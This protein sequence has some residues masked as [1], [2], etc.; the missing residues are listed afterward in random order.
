VNGH[1]I[2]LSTWCHEFFNDVNSK[3][4]GRSLR[5]VISE[6]L[7]LKRPDVE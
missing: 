3:F 6:G 4:D 5:V 7:C 1:L 2:V